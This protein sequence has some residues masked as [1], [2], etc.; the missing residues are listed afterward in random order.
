MRERILLLSWT[1]PPTSGGSGVIVANL[2]KQFSR[3]EMIVTGQR[4]FDRPSMTWREE[5]PRITYSTLG[6]PQTLRG[7]RWWRWLQLPWLVVR[8]IWLVRKHGCTGIL[9]VFPSE[10]FLL[11]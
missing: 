8:C 6:W 10:Q 2:A 4:S 3:D 5:W 9:V 7:G 11:A 1:V